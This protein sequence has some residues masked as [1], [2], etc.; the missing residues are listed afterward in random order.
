[1]QPEIDSLPE[2][3]P[4]RENLALRQQIPDILLVRPP[5]PGPGLA[6]RRSRRTL[7][8]PCH[9]PVAEVRT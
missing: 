7:A 8:V 3:C 5:H 2:E 6:E 9:T 4:L 1:M